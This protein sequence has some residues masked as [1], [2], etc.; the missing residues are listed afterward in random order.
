MV[1]GEVPSVR[2]AVSETLSPGVAEGPPVGGLLTPGLAAEEVGDRSA[3]VKNDLG[4]YDSFAEFVSRDPSKVFVHYPWV[5]RQLGKR[6]RGHRILDIGCGE[7]SLA[8]IL[9]REG[10]VVRGYDH[11]TGQIKRCRDGE[12]RE[13][14]GVGYFLADPRD[15]LG[16]L[17]PGQFDSAFAIAVLHCAED[18]EHLRTFFSSTYER[19]NFVSRYVM[20]KLASNLDYRTQQP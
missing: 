6:V 12:T 17:S 16:K 10:A 14:L 1:R 8:R 19:L 18:V 11:S 5:V 9:S 4:G 3:G 13:P 15:I 7:G 20:L 2:K